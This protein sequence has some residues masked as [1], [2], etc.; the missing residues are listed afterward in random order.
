MNIKASYRYQLADQSKSIF[1]YYIILLGIFLLLFL[2]M[3]V[4]I[5]TDD[6]SIVSGQF[7]GM[8]MATVIFVFI[9]GLNSF[10]EN[11]AML[12]QHGISRKTLF[13][14]RI[15]TALSVALVM[16]TIDQVLLLCFR[17]LTMISSDFL[18]CSSLYE[19][20]YLGEV[21]G[22]GSL[23]NHIA[24]YLF[25]IFLYLGFM[26]AGYLITLVFYRLNKAGK[27]AVGAG[28]PV[29]VFIVLPIF[30]YSVTGGKI[31]AAIFK[32]IDF[33]FGIS[34]H[35]PVNAMITCT[36]AFILFSGL[37]WLLVRRVD[38]KE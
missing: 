5:S 11:F 34:T 14:G 15:L 6:G 4:T 29:S 24:S 37:S 1:A 12:L 19:Q 10:K 30:D 26:A 25:N 3:T 16:A 38:V 8:E 36:I 20:I 7:G 18:S 13:V 27:V 9:A 23:T 31:S 2:S 17:A 33:A 22:M 21:T 32:F 35:Q 28:V